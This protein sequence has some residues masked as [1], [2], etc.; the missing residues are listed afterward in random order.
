MKK[1]LIGLI[2]IVISSTVMAQNTDTFFSVFAGGGINN[3]SKANSNI[4]KNSLPGITIGTGIT[5]FLSPNWGL[6]SGLSVDLTQ[7]DLTL[8]SMLERPD[9]DSEGDSYARRM[10][11]AAWKERQKI[12]HLSI[13][14]GVTY[15]LNP[16]DKWEWLASAGGKL[17]LP[18]SAR[19]KVQQGSLETKGYYSQWNIELDNI[20][21]LGY[22]TTTERFEGNIKSHPQWSLF[23][24]LGAFHR[25][26]TCWGVY[27]GAYVSYGLNNIHKCSDAELY[28]KDGTYNGIMNTGL[29]PSQRITMAGI[30][31]SIIYNRAKDQERTPID[32]VVNVVPA[33]VETPVKVETPIA[34][35]KAVETQPAVAVQ[36]EEPKATP[37]VAKTEMPV[38]PVKQKDSVYKQAQDLAEATEIIFPINQAHALR[39][40]IKNLTQLSK[41]LKANRNIHLLII[42]HTCS[43]GSDKV[44]KKIGM[45]RALYVKK[46]FLKH[47][48]SPRQLHCIS[49]ITEDRHG[50]GSKAKNRAQNRRV[51]LK[52]K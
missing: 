50:S 16:G 27:A 43:L 23:A 28:E 30:K 14:F 31:L 36:I 24:E 13:P 35:E 51:E 9:I 2:G 8:N 17:S 3:L 15:R 10:Y 20:P 22:T 29:A 39:E 49:K 11:Y 38:K 47:G 18:L 52:I 41:L 6:S 37:A 44:N 25:T 40:D 45:K 32:P 21:E 33:P 46:Q 48:V 26:K 4:S 42:G 1:Q 19:Y 7:S 5:H 34:T 12:Y